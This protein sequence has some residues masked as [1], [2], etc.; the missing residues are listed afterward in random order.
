MATILLKNPRLLV[1]L[2]SMLIVGGFTALSTLPRLEDPRPTNR[3]GTIIT[4]LGGASAERVEALVTEPLE[5]AIR[6]V[7]EIDFVESQSR[8]G[9]SVIGVEL[10][11]TV[12]DPDPIWSQVRD[13]MAE[14]ERH[15]PQD[16]SKP[17]LDTTRDAVAFSLIVGLVWDGQDQPQMGILSRFATELADRLRYLPHTEIARIYGAVEEQVIVTVDADE[18][19]L[20]ELSTMDLA[21]AIK[22]ADTK[23]PSGM[24]R[25]RDLDVIVQVDDDLDSIERIGRVPLRRGVG[26]DVLQLRHVAN[27]A[28]TSVGPP[29]QVA[30]VD[31]RRAVIV[32]AKI[33]E[34]ARLT[35]WAD[36]VEVL[37]DDF[38]RELP[39][40]IETD[41]IFEQLGYTNEQLNSLARNALIGTV[42]VMAVVLLLMGWRYALLVGAAIPLTVGAVLTAMQFLGIPLH[43]I[44]VIGLVIAL[45]LLIDNAIVTVNE[46]RNQLDRGATAQDAI[47]GAVGHL[48]IPLLGSTLTTILAFVPIVLVPGNVGDFIWTMGAGVI[49]AVGASFLI[50]MTIIATLAAIVRSSVRPNRTAQWWN[51]G[52]KLPALQSLARRIL[53]Q[54]VRRPALGI[55]IGG[56]L[57]VLGFAIAPLLSH[58]FFP[59]SDR[60]QFYVQVWGPGEASIDHMRRRVAELEHLIRA[61]P[62]VQR[63]DW[64]L[65]ASPPNFYYNMILN[66]DD[67]SNF[68]QAMV[69]ANSEQAAYRAVRNLQ[70]TIDTEAP[71]LQVVVRRLGQGPPVDAPIEIRLSGPSISTLRDLGD[72]VRR[73]L[74][75]MPEVVHSRSLLEGG[76][77]KLWVQTDEDEAHLAGL[78]LADVSAQL[79][80]NLEGSVGGLVLDDTEDLPVRIRFAN[81]RR[82]RMDAVRS[83]NLVRPDGSG[84]IPISALGAV[85]ARPAM[86]IISR[87]DGQRTNTIQA[88]IDPDTLPDEANTALLQRLDA[89]GLG[90]ETVSD[91]NGT[92]LSISTF[93]QLFSGAISWLGE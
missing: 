14:A 45:G 21:R 86:S 32:A 16:A 33:E 26:G 30:L 62:G 22:T 61:E 87:R 17:T 6:E 39:A 50:S 82:S 37:L 58:Q 2:I 10:K 42:I 31:G 85:T 51:A 88:Y 11:A 63:V 67:V 79:Q 43:Q 55:A 69:H 78:T 49:L 12:T 84:W 40:R 66:Q 57:P 38:R 74:A 81:D 64:V 91:T 70:R 46:I 72:Q 24:I 27:V 89:S 93:A 4:R 15:L 56:L 9:V 73:H 65:G 18:L 60:D 83:V 80:G 25:G 1:L 75:Q 47:R 23:T 71:D 52:L 54:S 59:A 3:R 48:F 20:L 7:S 77:V 92:R 8:S 53:V 28:K 13:R 5:R 68:A 35:A 76:Q 36:E 90:R 44:S 19:A 34:G 29:R 41:V